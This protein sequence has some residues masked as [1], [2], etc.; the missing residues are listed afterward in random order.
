MGYSTADIRKIALVGQA[1]SGKTL[2][3]EA[4]LFRAGAIRAMGELARGT[5]VCDHD[6]LEKEYQ[7]SLDT[8]V[9]HLDHQG[10]RI[11]LVDTPGYPDL[12]GRSLS[13]LPAIETAAVVVNAQS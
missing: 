12:L 10:K 1:A 2:L 13:I 7:H 4:L 6:P 5:T 11:N 8:A 3:A 9:C